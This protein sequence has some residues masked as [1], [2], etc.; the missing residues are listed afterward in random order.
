[1][2]TACS[3]VAVF[4]AKKPLEA[5]KIR[6]YNPTKTKVSTVIFALKGFRY[7]AFSESC[8][9]VSMGIYSIGSIVNQR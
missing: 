5:K 1:M 7:L 2:P 4:S 6:R 8:I 3:E 9:S